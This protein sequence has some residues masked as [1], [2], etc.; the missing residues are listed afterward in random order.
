MNP[1]KLNIQSAMLQ[2]SSNSQGPVARCAPWIAWDLEILL[3]FDLGVLS[4]IH[5]P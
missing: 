5:Q 1:T 4:F 2:G 3:S